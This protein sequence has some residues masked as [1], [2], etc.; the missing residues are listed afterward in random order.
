MRSRPIILFDANVFFGVRL[1]SL[2]LFL[3]ETGLFLARWTEKINDEWI[4]N[5]HR[6][7]AIPLETLEQLR[8][9]VNRSVPD[10]LVT[11]F[12]AIEASLELPDPNDRHVLAAALKAQADLII[13][14][15]GK[16]FPEAVLDPLGLRASH[17]DEFLMTMLDSAPTIFAQ[18]VQRDF[19]H[20][21]APPF[22]SAQYVSALH[23]AGVVKTANRTDRLRILTDDQ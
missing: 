1:R 2:M 8:V 14:F 9:L 10:C 7:Q 22:T 13:T 12:E 6:K 17:P 23:R 19:S 16:D 21:N 20:Y 18:A 11:D 15:N 3:A 5:I 4:R